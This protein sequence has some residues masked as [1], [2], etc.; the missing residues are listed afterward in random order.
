MTGTVP[1]AM[2]LSLSVLHGLQDPTTP[3]AFGLREKIIVP[4]SVRVGPQIRCFTWLA[5]DSNVGPLPGERIDCE[6]GV[7]L[8]LDSLNGRFAGDLP[9][10]GGVADVGDVLSRAEAVRLRDACD[11]MIAHG[12]EL[13][14]LVL[15]GIRII[16]VT[17]LVPDFPITAMNHDLRFLVDGDF[18]CPLDGGL[19]SF[20]VGRVFFCVI[21]SHGP[22]ILTFNYMLVWHTPLM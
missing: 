18:P 14:A 17:I 12:F 4:R 13:V 5:D 9:V 6:E 2:T 10:T 20:M 16:T 7:R 1:L 3:V 8:R 11:L 19:L 15:R 22:T 21:A